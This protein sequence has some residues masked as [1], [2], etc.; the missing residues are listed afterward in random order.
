MT[1][2]TEYFRTVHGYPR[3]VRCNFYA[4]PDMICMDITSQPW[5]ALTPSSRGMKVA[6]MN[7]I[8][9]LSLFAW[10]HIYQFSTHFAFLSLSLNLTHAVQNRSSTKQVASARTV[11]H[12]PW[13][14]FSFPS[15]GSDPGSRLLPQT[16]S[17]P[18]YFAS[19]QRRYLIFNCGG[20]R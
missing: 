20:A 1:W 15:P 18:Y 2:R 5:S 4:T 3:I 16:M 9:G 14:T 12:E 7:D 19:P 8:T 10:P 17:S 11:V 6:C 13:F